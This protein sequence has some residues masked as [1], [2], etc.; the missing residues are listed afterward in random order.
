MSEIILQCGED[1]PL[2]GNITFFEAYMFVTTDKF[3]TEHGDVENGVVV[4]GNAL[5]WLEMRGV[6]LLVIG[7]I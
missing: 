7:Q 3:L 2:D 4:A 1:Y 6:F 5:L